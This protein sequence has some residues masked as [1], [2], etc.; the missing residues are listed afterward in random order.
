MANVTLK[1]MFK[2]YER[3]TC[4]VSDFSLDVLVV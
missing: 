1:N 2:D 3:G 4:V